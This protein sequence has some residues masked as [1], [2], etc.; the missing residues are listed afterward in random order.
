M[1]VERRAGKDKPVIAKALTRL[2]GFPMK[3]LMRHRN[4]WILHNDFVSPG[5]LQFK[6]ATADEISLTL[7]L[8]L[9]ERHVS[10]GPSKSKKRRKNDDSDSESVKDPSSVFK[11]AMCE[12]M[13][14]PSLGRER[15]VDQSTDLVVSD[16]H[17]IKKQ[18]KKTV[19]RLKSAV[20]NVLSQVFPK[21]FPKEDFNLIDLYHSSK[22]QTRTKKMTI[23]VVFCGRQNPAAHAAVFG[24]IAE[25]D[26]VEVLGFLNGTKGLFEG[27]AM[28]LDRKTVSLF[29][30]Q[31]GMD[32]LCRTSDSMRTPEQLKSIRQTVRFVYFENMIQS[33]GFTETLPTNTGTKASS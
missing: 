3:E 13:S 31:G 19:V 33:K 1:N 7:R 24:L 6:G 30:N 28:K 21:T 20:S 23:G 18:S 12:D 4:K 17:K 2:D 32:L 9:Y 29:R 10:S 26:N 5:P 14:I 8:E 15:A 16:Q 11:L 22:S 27:R 25:N